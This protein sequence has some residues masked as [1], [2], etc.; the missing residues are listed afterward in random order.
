MRPRSGSSSRRVSR[1]LLGI[2][3][4]GVLLGVAHT[5]GL[6]NPVSTL[7]GDITQPFQSGFSR[8]G[9]AVGSW[10]DVIGSA[11]QQGNQNQ[12]LRARVAALQ[13][14]VS[15]DTEIKAQND[16]LRK[17]LGVG[18]IAPDRLVAAEVIGY[19][20]D[21]FRQFVTIDR[22]SHDG[23]KNGMAVVEQGDL[24]GTVEEVTRSSAKVFL[25]IDPNFRVA[26]LD[27]NEPD[28]PTG[29]ITGQIGNGLTM[30]EIAQTE[31]LNAG[32]TIVTSGLGGSVEKGLIIGHIQG[33]NKQDNGVFQT[34][35]VSSDVQFN[36]LD[37]V[38]VVVRP[39]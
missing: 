36:R 22:G 31:T 14:Q 34:A 38:Y 30:N 10:F 11:S 28:R 23:L 35:Q 7:V 27:Q 39:Q 33:V 17:Q 8:A 32:D 25:I 24:I 6:L 26:A 29:T 20:P 9:N 13:Q 1:R 2:M 15:Q 21:N 18:T 5:T 3:A 19:Q 16:E 12:R 4:F 37:I